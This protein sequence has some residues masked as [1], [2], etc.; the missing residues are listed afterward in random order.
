MH[1]REHSSK[2][3]DKIQKRVILAPNARYKEIQS[4][5]ASMKRQLVQQIDNIHVMLAHLDW[6]KAAAVWKGRLNK[7]KSPNEL[8]E[9]YMEQL[10]PDLSSTK[11]FQNIQYWMLLSSVDRNLVDKF[12]DVQD[13][14]YH[15]SELQQESDI[16]E[17][18]LMQQFEQKKS[19]AKDAS[20]VSIVKRSKVSEVW[21]LISKSMHV[22]KKSQ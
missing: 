4:T 17:K 12:L 8:R 11:G 6:T 7:R 18:Q 10:S 9:F 15:M 19:I 13:K 14:L 2:S 3:V 5:I 16:L 20:S 1:L 22:R 21:P